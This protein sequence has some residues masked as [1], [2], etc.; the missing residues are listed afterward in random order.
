LPHGL[1]HGH[2][3]ARRDHGRAPRADRGRAGAGSGRDRPHPFRQREPGDARAHRA[4]SIALPPTLTW[5]AMDPDAGDVLTHDVQLGT[6]FATSGQS[7]ARTCPAS[8]GPDPREAPVAGYD[9]ANDRLILFGGAGTTDESLW[10]LDNASAAGGPSQWTSIPTAGGPV[11]LGHAASAYDAATNRL[12][13]V[14]G[15]S[16]DCLGSSDQTWIL[17]HANGLGGTP[18]WSLLPGAGP[19]P[20]I[21]HAAAIDPATR[22][23]IVFGG[24]NAG[25]SLGDVWLLSLDGL[26]AWQALPAGG[27]GPVRSGMTASYDPE[28]NVLVVF[29][30]RSGTQAFADTWVLS[31]ANGSGGSAVWSRLAPAGTPPPGRWGHVAAYD[32]VTA[33]LVVYGG[34]TASANPARRFVFRDVW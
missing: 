8:Q 24:S 5:S 17:T 27:S 4:N 1:R 3:R 33:R 6:S 30:G 34:S 13:V 15:C 10:I 14:G 28:R 23:L 25:S 19:G 26:S 18:T 16:G 29:G 20:R 9:E 2:L 7:W 32:P 11:G 12:F 22:R 21:D 31:H